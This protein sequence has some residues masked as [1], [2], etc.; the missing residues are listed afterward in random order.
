[1]VAMVTHPHCPTFIYATV[2]DIDYQSLW[3]MGV[4]VLC[5]DIENTLG[6]MGCDD[7]DKDIR[8]LFKRLQRMGFQIILATNSTRDFSGL[9]AELDVDI[10]QPEKAKHWW[11]RK[12]PRKPQRFFFNRLIDKAGGHYLPRHMAMIGDK[13]MHDVSAAMACGMIGILINPLGPD[14]PI[15][16]KLRLRQR[17]AR[18]MKR[19]EISRAA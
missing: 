18:V 16:D 6:L 19:L 4:R 3:D 14:L 1:M 7:F 11:K 5:F 10:M 2:H 9:T 12:Y 13:L 15:E 8:A 17:E